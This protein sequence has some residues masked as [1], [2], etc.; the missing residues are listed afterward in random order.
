MILEL[1]IKNLVLIEEVRLDLDSGFVVFTGETGAGKSLLVKAIKLL[2]GE[3]GGKNYIRPDAETGEVSAI[4]WGGDELAK[5]LEKL[6]HSP[7]KE[8]HIKRI[9]SSKRQKTYINGD[10]VTLSELSFLTKDLIILTSQHEFYTL[11]NPEKQ[12]EFLDEF[13]GLDSQKREFIDIFEKY[14]KISSEIK[15]LENKIAEAELKKD[16][17]LFQIGE[18]EELNPDPEEEKSLLKEREKLKNLSFLKENLH[19]LLSNFE[20]GEESLSQAISILEK[21]SNVETEFNDY[22]S[23]LYSFYYE[24]KEIARDMGSYLSQ[25][26]ED[27]TYLNQ[28]EERLEK[29]ERLKRKYK[30]DTSGLVELLKELREELRLLDSGEER[31]EKLKKKEEELRKSVLEAAT[32]LSRERLR[33]A[34][35]LQELL[36]KELKDLGMEKAEFKVKLKSKEPDVKN[37]SSSGLDEIRFL[38]SPNPGVPLRPLEKVASG[39]ELSRIFLALRSILQERASTGTLIFD[40]VDTGIGGITA[41][42]VAQKIKNL[43]QN[44]QVLCI[45]HLPQIA[46][47]ADSHYVVEK[48]MT[49][50]KTQTKIK[51]VEG[52][53]RLKEIARMLGDPENLELA[54][55]FIKTS[56]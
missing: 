37:L 7:E 38:F 35:K 39:G 2:L 49:S 48:E 11:L 36:K 34:S 14:K 16:F 56:S 25:L 9:I 45:T 4:I 12:L 22:L 13:L 8:I 17:I 27:D 24:I 3:K 28:I 53:E 23:K 30:R 42:K 32:K 6:G 50:N 5:R 31:F 33:G 29:Y 44:Y 43:S 47:L 40:E 46:V 10:P 18:L 26:P 21:I 51:R 41:K 15:E 55:K 52:K 54:K 19:L 20:Q 1:K